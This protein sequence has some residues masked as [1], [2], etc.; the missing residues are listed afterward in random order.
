A[1][2]EPILAILFKTSAFSPVGQIK[3]SPCFMATSAD[4]SDCRIKS[5]INRCTTG[6]K[7]LILEQS[8]KNW[9]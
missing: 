5:S 9:G 8:F 1:S 7:I 4:E 6:G 3:K 2:A